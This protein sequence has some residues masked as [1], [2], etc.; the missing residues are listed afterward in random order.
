M[1]IETLISRRRVGYYGKYI[2]VIPDHAA[3]R[4]RRFTVYLIPAS[5][6]R[7]IHIIGREVTLG[8]ARI[9]KN[10]Y[11]KIRVKDHE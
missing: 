4:P 9:L 11:E 7:R 3:G 2:V 8:T 6:S 10:K 5:P 1:K